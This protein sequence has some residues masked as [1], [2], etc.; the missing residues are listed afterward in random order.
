MKFKKGQKLGDWVLIE[1]IGWG[2]NGEVW[3]CQKGDEVRAVKILSK[4]NKKSYGRFKREIHTIIELQGTEGI[5]PI[6]DFFLP[7]TY[8]SGIP[9]YVM[10]VAKPAFPEFKKLNFKEKLDACIR[11]TKTIKAC[12]EKNIGHRDIKPKNILFHKQNF[13]LCDFGLVKKD[14]GQVLSKNENKIGPWKTIAPE[15]RRN[16]ETLPYKADVF[17]LAKTFWIFLSENENSFD[18]QFV[19]NETLS[20]DEKYKNEYLQPLYTLFEKCT[21]HDLEK[22]PSIN[23]LLGE[24]QYYLK[25]RDEWDER[26][27]YQWRELI[28]NLFPMVVPLRTVWTDTDKILKILKMISKYQDLNHM[29]YPTGGGVDLDS[30]E[31]GREKNSIT[32]NYTEIMF[33]EK[34]TLECCPENEWNY[35]WLQLKNIEPIFSENKGRFAE[36]LVDY[37]SKEYVNESYESATQREREYPT[38]SEI[39]EYMRYLKGAFVIFAKNSPYNIGNY[40]LGG[41]KKFDAYQPY[42]EKL[43]EEDFRKLINKMRSL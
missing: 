40:S 23:D 41:S 8:D 4:I 36:Y 16:P 33:P 2:G 25:L 10:P 5:L 9:F 32:I 15:M 12:H 31:K 35:F 1:K 11:L 28:N 22:R 7:K 26:I 19:S 14:D 30:A 38:G 37:D 17:S 18:G 3:K 6:Y 42:H 20:F 13:Y 43:G 34:L 24:L 27:S 29:F 39:K 21:E